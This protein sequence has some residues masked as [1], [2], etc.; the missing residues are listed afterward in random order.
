[1][2]II[3]GQSHKKGDR[4]NRSGVKLKDPKRVATANIVLMVIPVKGAKRRNRSK[5]DLP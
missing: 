1:M 2:A 3:A 4:A 5:V